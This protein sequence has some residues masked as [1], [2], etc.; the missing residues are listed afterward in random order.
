MQYLNLPSNFETAPCCVSIC[1]A[2]SQPLKPKRDNS[3]KRCCDTN[4]LNAC[5]LD[6]PLPPNKF[7]ADTEP[8]DGTFDDNPTENQ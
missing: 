3:N 8:G 2:K 5:A 6:G 4:V 7:E 1:C